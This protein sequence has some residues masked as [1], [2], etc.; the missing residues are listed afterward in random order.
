MSRFF[1]MRNVFG[2]LAI[3]AGLAVSEAHATEVTLTFATLPNEETIG[4][5][6]N[7]GLSGFPPDGDGPNDGLVFSPK[8]DELKDTAIKTTDFGKFENNPSGLNGVFYFPG[9]AGANS[10]YINDIN[11]F[12]DLSFYYSL[13]GNSAT[14]ETTVDIYSGLSG[15]GT[16]LDTINLTPSSSPVACTNPVVGVTDEFCTWALAD[17]TSFTVPGIGESAVFGPGGLDAPTNNIEFDKL[18]IGVPEPSTWAIVLAGLFA[19]D[20]IRR[21]LRQKGAVATA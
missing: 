11:G 20:F 17:V 21:G 7:G 14:Y 4:N 3:G 12:T 6:F 1:K 15:A 2:I 18:T 13:N 8:A 16:L 10:S 9:A 5:Y 19:V